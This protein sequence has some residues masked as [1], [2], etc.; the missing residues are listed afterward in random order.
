MGRPE[1]SANRNVPDIALS[2]GFTNMICV[3]QPPP[4]AKSGNTDDE[5]VAGGE[6]RSTTG[7]VV[8]MRSE[9]SL[10]SPRRATTAMGFEA[11][12]VNVPENAEGP[13]NGMSF[14]KP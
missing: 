14:K 5:P 11:L 13:L 7:S 2:A 9:R 12:N 4:S 10:R 1:G 8:Q 6:P 3:L